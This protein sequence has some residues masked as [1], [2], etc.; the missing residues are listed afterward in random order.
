MDE[1]ELAVLEL[2]LFPE[3]FKN[4][5]D[6]CKV[7]VDTTTHVIGDVLKKL[8]HDE[9]VI[10]LSKNEKGEFVRSIGYDS[11]DMNNFHYQL[12]AKGIDQLAKN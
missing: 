9:F 3:N 12:S 1:V 5:V 11:D 8:L 4:I 7:K 2:L 6:E 10:P